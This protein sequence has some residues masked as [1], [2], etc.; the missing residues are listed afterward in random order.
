MNVLSINSHQG[1]ELQKFLPIPWGWLKFLGGLLNVVIL[2]GVILFGMYAVMFWTTKE[3]SEGVRLSISVFCGGVFLLFVTSY[4]M[5]GARGRWIK[6]YGNRNVRG[7]VVRF[8]IPDGPN[9]PTWWADVVTSGEDPMVFKPLLPFGGLAFELGLGG[10]ASFGGTGIV[11]EGKPVGREHSL[12]NWSV[13]LHDVL[14]TGA[15]LVCVEYTHPSSSGK[16]ECVVLE[17]AEAIRLLVFVRTTRDIVSIS[18][19]LVEY[20]RSLRDSQDEVS[21]LMASRVEVG[22]DLEAALMDVERLTRERDADVER[23]RKQL[24]SVVRDREALVFA[25]VALSQQIDQTD[26]LKET[27]EGLLVH[28]AIATAMCIHFENLRDTQWLTHWREKR[29]VVEANLARKRRGRR[30]VAS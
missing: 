16:R 20:R 12:H 19:A 1:E 22:K 3:L 26:R 21:R 4:F 28:K 29:A 7:Y 15:V 8:F 23:L 14:N 18:D 13:C 10:W 27:I 17:V 30:R 24:K 6:A 2:F 11:H 25:L 9:L 5:S